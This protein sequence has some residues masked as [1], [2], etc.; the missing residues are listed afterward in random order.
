M[1]KGQQ[2]T[3]KGAVAI[4]QNLGFS[5][6][7]VILVVGLVVF[8]PQKLPELGRGLGQAIREFRKATRTITEEVAR[9]ATDEGERTQK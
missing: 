3:S 9:A 5:E 6:L 4:F 1:G 8:G 7:L 2:H